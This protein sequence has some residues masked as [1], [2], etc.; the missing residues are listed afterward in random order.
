MSIRV[1]RLA[2]L[3][4]RPPA[5]AA[6]A[7]PSHPSCTSSPCSSSLR[8]NRNTKSAQPNSLPL[9]SASL[10]LFRTLSCTLTC[11]P[12]RLRPLCWRPS[13]P[14]AAV[15]AIQQYHSIHLMSYTPASSLAAQLHPSTCASHHPALPP[16][17]PSLPLPPQASPCFW[18]LSRFDRLIFLHFY[19]KLSQL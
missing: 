19:Q 18:H 17:L 13:R 12:L 3:I 10:T 8:G 7:I 4:G 5:A 9:D 1:C 11:K 16:L 15:R 14:A 2:P 6:S